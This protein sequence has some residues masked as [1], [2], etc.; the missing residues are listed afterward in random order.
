[1]SASARL[2]DMNRSTRHELTPAEDTA[3]R[4]R[5]YFALHLKRGLGALGQSA[6]KRLVS[7]KTGSESPTQQ[8]TSAVLGQSSAFAAWSALNKGSQRRM[9]VAISDMVDR[10]LPELEARAREIGDRAKLGSLEL[11]AGVTLPPYLLNTAFHGQPGG[12][13]GTRD[14][15]D[16]RAGVLQ[17]SGGTLYTRGAGTGRRDSKAQAVVRF[18]GERFPDLKPRRVLDL[19]CGYGGQTCGYALAFPMAETHG[20]DL[21]EAQL[22]YGHLRAESLGVALHLRQADAAQPGFPDGH[23]DLIVSNILLHE[24]PTPVM[25]EI[26]TQCWRLLAPGGVVIHQDVPTQAEAMPGFARYMALWQ[27]EHNDE[28]FWSD[29]AD[30]DVPGAL[31]EAG[32][33][34]DAVF[35]AYVPQVDGP[36]TW[37]FVGAQRS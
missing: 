34:D 11:D 9:W 8:D 36:L 18:L 7:A 23:F 21:G 31:V 29:F 19:G 20:I 14:G 1:M 33:S 37:Y 2:E 12:Y 17:E 4:S 26:M 13:V 22:R 15:D 5:Q 30:S 27:T 35:E 10:Q 28:P 3:D 25:R 24:V 16:I 6:F 32:F